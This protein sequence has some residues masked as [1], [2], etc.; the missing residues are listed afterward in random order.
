MPLLRKRLRKQ[1][2]KRRRATKTRNSSAFL[3]REQKIAQMRARPKVCSMRIS[4]DT[5]GRLRGGGAAWHLH[6]KLSGVTVIFF[7]L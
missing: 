1:K 5:V 3:P 2:S 4:P 7:L 6:T